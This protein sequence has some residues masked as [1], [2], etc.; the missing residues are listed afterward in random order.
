MLEEILLNLSSCL[1]SLQ[2][3]NESEL[4]KIHK[5][6]NSDE[7]EIIARQVKRLYKETEK[8]RTDC[9]IG[10]LT[11]IGIV[12]GLIK[13]PDSGMPISVIV[14]K[15]KESKKMSITEYKKAIYE[16]K[17]KNL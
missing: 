1:L 13:N 12:N 9:L 14:S 8:Y 16:Y 10:D 15:N 5:L 11:P 17:I 6:L 2:S 4:K 7:L 3:L